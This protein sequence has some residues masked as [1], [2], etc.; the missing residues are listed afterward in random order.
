VDLVRWL[1]RDRAR[2]GDVVGSFYLL[3]AA[4][5]LLAI[6]IFGLIDRYL[7]PSIP[8]LVGAVA[9]MRGHVPQFIDARSKTARYVA[10]G[11]LAGFSVFA[12]ASTK[13]YLSWNRVRWNALNE[14]MTAYHIGPQ[15]I[16]GG[17]EFNALYLY[18]PNYQ[19]DPR[20]GWWWVQGDK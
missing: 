1:R 15:D 3:C 9:G 13:D 4:V 10:D 6:F 8:F 19:F 17:F 2:E 14:L 7:V 18:D 20:K 5:Y 11:L 16:D 12:I